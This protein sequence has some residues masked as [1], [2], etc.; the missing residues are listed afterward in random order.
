[1]ELFTMSSTPDLILVNGKFT[2]LD[3]PTRRPTR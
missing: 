1:L 2:T 3:K